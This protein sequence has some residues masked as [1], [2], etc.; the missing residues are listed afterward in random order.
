VTV[1]SVTR[2]GSQITAQRI[3]VRY[4]VTMDTG[5]VHPVMMHTAHKKH[6]VESYKNN[7]N[8]TPQ[9][10]QHVNH[11]IVRL[12][13]AH[14]HEAFER[15]CDTLAA[16]IQ[17]DGFAIQP[18]AAPYEFADAAAG[19]YFHSD[20]VALGL[21]VHCFPSKPTPASTTT[22]SLAGQDFAD[23]IQVLRFLWGAGEGLNVSGN[24]VVV[25]SNLASDTSKAAASYAR[26]KAKP[27]FLTLTTP[28]EQAALAMKLKTTV[29]AFKAASL[30][31]TKMVKQPMSVPFK[32]G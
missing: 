26:I 31:A 11:T 20:A 1:Q 28:L 2:T 16:A 8:Y 29:P 17:A 10:G 14:F 32:P 22:A 12:P 4:T 3:E 15:Y 30:A 19:C 27:W 6:V 9:V 13:L 7:E 21:N 25:G 24:A 23:F 5:A 18:K